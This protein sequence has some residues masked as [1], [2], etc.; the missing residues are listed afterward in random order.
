MKASD[1]SDKLILDY[2]YN[3]QGRWTMLWDDNSLSTWVEDV[4]SEKK[5]LFPVAAPNKVVRAKMRSLYKRGLVG[6]C[7]C[8][9]RGDF[10]ITDKGLTFLGKPRTKPYSGY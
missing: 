3:F 8:G 4:K 6:G 1:I 2:L 7:D 9:C 10:E 5:D